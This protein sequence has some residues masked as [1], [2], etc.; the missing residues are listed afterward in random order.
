MVDIVGVSHIHESRH[1]FLQ[2]STF[3][4]RLIIVRPG[5]N[6]GSLDHDSNVDLDRLVFTLPDSHVLLQDLVQDVGLPGARIHALE[7]PDQA[8]GHTFDPQVNVQSVGLVRLEESVGDRHAQGDR[9]S[10]LVRANHIVSISSTITVLLL[11]VL[12]DIGLGDTEAPVS[13]VLAVLLHELQEVLGPLANFLIARVDGVGK[14]FED[15]V[16]KVDDLVV[17]FGLEDGQDAGHVSGR[18]VA[19]EDHSQ[20][21]DPGFVVFLL[22]GKDG[23]EVVNAILD[24]GIPSG[25]PN[26]SC[27]H[28]GRF[29]H[30]SIK[31]RLDLISNT[32]VTDIFQS[33]QID[34]FVFTVISILR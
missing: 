3:R 9:G 6:S 4:S 11:L 29:L 28:F 19:V 26:C 7:L 8:L 34:D 14:L 16:S 27:L 23:E 21:G 18:G 5:D 13:F 22:V 17:C 10:G 1:E 20:G 32:S 12:P 31:Q 33:I 25:N 24:S 2:T 15:A 30:L